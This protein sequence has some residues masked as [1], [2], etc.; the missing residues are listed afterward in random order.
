MGRWWSRVKDAR[1]AWAYWVPRAVLLVAPL[2][3]VVRRPSGHSAVVAW[4]VVVVLYAGWLLH[5][6][7]SALMV[8][9]FVLTALAALA[10]V[11]LGR[12]KDWF[13]G[14][15][16]KWWVGVITGVVVLV[17]LRRQVGSLS[18]RFI[19]VPRP[20][21]SDEPD[22]PLEVTS[23]NAVPLVDALDSLWGSTREGGP[24]YGRRA[25]HNRGSGAKGHFVTARAGADP[26]WAIP[27]F[28]A[29]RLEATARFSNFSGAIHR[30]DSL[31]A[32]HGLAV[33]LQPSD[34]GP[35]GI[36]L[37][38]VDIRRFPVSDRDV[39]FGF[40]DRYGRWL[41]LVLF[42]LANRTGLLALKGM[43]P[44]LPP[45]S[46]ATRTYHGLNTFL[47]KGKPVRYRLVPRSALG[48]AT[49]GDRQTRLDRDL[50]G[51][52]HDGPLLFD[53]QLIRGTGLPDSVLYDARRAWP[54]WF[55]PKATIGQLVLDRYV[56]PREIDPLA[57][58]PHRL[59]VGV[60]PSR[61]E[62]L[63]ARRAA[64]A[65]SQLRRCPV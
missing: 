42:W 18:P 24:R 51:R 4:I 33:R 32:P 23:D 41:R 64:Y 20:D 19:G 49:I 43:V 59:P 16:W 37:V 26:W 45:L 62:V 28:G 63:M 61:D 65:E 44:I 8:R 13:D 12:A 22:N 14:G 54:R 15:G 38:L 52:L 58:D 6:V 10:I 27:L 35:A 55:M 1:H 31:R 5:F 3:L 47:W 2:V 57:F 17:L 30:D 9:L 50:Q 48:G 34:P 25:V 39:F 21:A 7:L 40:I 53:V 36:D 60:E 46:Y 56:A 29:S 11:E